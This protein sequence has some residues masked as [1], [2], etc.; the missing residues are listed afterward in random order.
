MRSVAVLCLFFSAVPFSAGRVKTPKSENA[1][2]DAQS[3]KAHGKHVS[4][5]IKTNRSKSA[6]RPKA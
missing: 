3:H 4:K 5:K 1:R 6:K 2:A